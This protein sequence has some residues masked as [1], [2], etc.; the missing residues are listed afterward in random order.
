MWTEQQKRIIEGKFKLTG[1]DDKRFVFH[2]SK[3]DTEDYYV[4]YD[5]DKIDVYSRTGVL[6]SNFFNSFQKVFIKAG[7]EKLEP[8]G[9]STYGYGDVNSYIYG[10]NTATM[11]IEPMAHGQLEDF[12][13]SRRYVMIRGKPLYVNKFN[14]EFTENDYLVIDEKTL[15]HDII[16]PQID[17]IQLIDGFSL[18]NYVRIETLGNRLYTTATIWTDEKLLSIIENMGLIEVPEHRPTV[19]FDYIPFEIRKIVDIVRFNRDGKLELVDTGSNKY[20]A[21][22]NRKKTVLELNNFEE[23]L[24]MDVVQQRYKV[25]FSKWPKK[26]T[27]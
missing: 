18:K 7:N 21:T 1:S 8:W 14:R 12:P 22:L 27:S 24:R 25:W 15:A 19:V 23:L 3:R 13:Y 11:K 16:T 9:Q 2:S 20:L 5:I 26:K 4:A 10:L 6:G 17:D